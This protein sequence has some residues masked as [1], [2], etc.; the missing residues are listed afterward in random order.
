MVLI[1]E[2]RAAHVVI[3]KEVGRGM[4]VIDREHVAA[5]KAAADFT[6]P[7]A[8]F[9][10][11][12]R[13]LAFAECN[14]LRRKILGDGAS[15]SGAITSTK[16]PSRKSTRISFNA[17]PSSGTGF[18][19]CKLSITT[20]CTGSASTSSLEKKHPARDVRRNLGRSGEMPDG[21]VTL[22]CDPCLFASRSGS[23]YA[24]YRRAP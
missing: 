14:T 5:F 11:S 16:R 9:Q 20:R 13:V 10:S 8:R 12:F 23:L 1:G 6:D 15:R 2:Q 3:V 7:V 21:R 19:L 17:P 4:A 22:R 24:T 18:S